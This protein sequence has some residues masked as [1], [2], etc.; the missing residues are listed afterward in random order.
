MLDFRGIPFLLSQVNYS[1][2]SSDYFIWLKPIVLI[3]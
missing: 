2:T 1:L 3:V